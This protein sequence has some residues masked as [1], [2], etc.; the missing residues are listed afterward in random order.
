MCASGGGDQKV[1][2]CTCTKLKFNNMQRLESV[3]IIIALDEMLYYAYGLK[4]RHVSVYK[5]NC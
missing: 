5:I 1:Y 2:F 3:S 4:G